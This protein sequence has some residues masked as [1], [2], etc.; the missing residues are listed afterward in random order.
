MHEQLNKMHTHDAGLRA[1]RMQFTLRRFATASE[2]SRTRDRSPIRSD[3][4]CRAMPAAYEARITRAFGAR[5]RPVAFSTS[6]WSQGSWPLG[7]P[8]NSAR[9]QRLHEDRTFATTLRPL[10]THDQLTKAV[11]PP[12]RQPPQSQRLRPETPAMS[13]RH[14]IESSV[15]REWVS[16]A[17]VDFEQNNKQSGVVQ[18]TAAM[19]ART[20]AFRPPHMAGGYSDGFLFLPPGATHLK[21]VPLSRSQASLDPLRLS[22][23][24]SGLSRSVAT[25]RLASPASPQ[26]HLP[27]QM[28]F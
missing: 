14:G 22:R 3:P 2:A 10:G 18:A 25:L 24:P 15:M 20:P 11:M 4:G 28:S 13:V 9:N 6:A 19:P 26:A 27:R 1:Q 17:V 12:G 8:L 21:K 23:S 16:D 7:F 5:E